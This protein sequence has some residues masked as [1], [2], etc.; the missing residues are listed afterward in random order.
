LV[1]LGKVANK[2][3]EFPLEFITGG[4]NFVTSE[5]VTYFR[6][7]LGE[8]LPNYVKLKKYPVLG[9]SLPGRFAGP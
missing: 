9:S 8:E 7:L 4:N 2:I 3:R 6:P 5:F 1:E